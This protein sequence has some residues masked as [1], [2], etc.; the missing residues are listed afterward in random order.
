PHRTTLKDLVRTTLAAG[1]PGALGELVAVIDRSAVGLAELHA[2]GAAATQTLSWT[3]ELAEVREVIDRLAILVPSLDGTAAGLLADLEQIAAAAPPQP[4]VPAHGSFRPAQV[5]VHGGG[6]GF[7][8]FD[9]F[10]MT[11][12]ARDAALFCAA[13]RDTALRALR[14]RGDAVDDDRAHLALADE[15]CQGFLAAYD[16]AA[17]LSAPRVALWETLDVL[18]AVLHCWTKVK[19]E[20]LPYRMALLEHRLQRG[21][22]GW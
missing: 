15:L 10:C 13:L 14:S 3:E 9:S 17:P 1:E 18:T 21:L 2:S 5:V 6:I 16:A 4:A 20:R 12:P 19:F 8:D 7:I 11:E 22:G